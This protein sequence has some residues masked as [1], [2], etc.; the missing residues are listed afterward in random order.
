MRRYTEWTSY[1]R[2][3]ED[4]VRKDSA[5]W[6]IDLR[7]DHAP[8][9]DRAY[10]AEMLDEMRCRSEDRARV[11]QLNE[12]LRAEPHFANMKDFSGLILAVFAFLNNITF[13]YCS[14]HTLTQ[15]QSKTL[16][17]LA[18]DTSGKAFL[19]AVG[20][21]PSREWPIETPT[22]STYPQGHRRSARSL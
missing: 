5:V 1:I 11:R 22:I 17:Y 20:C 7:D 16:A 2:G 3:Q 21:C 13:L 15:V 10:F 4:N 14:R 8:S 19:H 12:F 18:G 9:N 6:L